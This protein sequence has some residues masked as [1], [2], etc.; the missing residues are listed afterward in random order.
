MLQFTKDKRKFLH[1]KGNLQPYNLLFNF[2][3]KIKAK[4][5][6][7]D[8]W[9]TDISSLVLKRI[10][11]NSPMKESDNSRVV[12]R[13]GR[14]NPLQGLRKITN[15]YAKK[16]KKQGWINRGK[17][18]T[19]ISTTKSYQLLSKDQDMQAH[20]KVKK[21]ESRKQDE[22]N[23]FQNKQPETPTKAKV[24]IQH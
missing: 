2:H 12:Q 9:T 23:C 24:E 5:S 3:L 10:P 14:G 11:R 7:N 4:N 17:H 1:K 20:S 16:R 22:L 15:C 21:Q 18:T 8:Y 13:A 19:F 6:P